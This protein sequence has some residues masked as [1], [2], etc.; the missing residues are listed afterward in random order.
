ML[1]FSLLLRSVWVS[2]VVIGTT[3]VAP[4]TTQAQFSA[5]KRVAVSM[6]PTMVSAKPG[7]SFTL[8]LTATPQSGWY[9]YGL[10]PS[11]DADGIGPQ[12]TEISVGANTLI[13]MNGT[14]KA[15]KPKQKFDKGFQINV[16]YYDSKTTLTIPVRVSATAK[17]G[18][19]TAFALFSY[20]S[21]D[22][23]RCLPPDED[24]LKFTLTI[25][26]AK[27]NAPTPTDTA[28]N[29]Q[30]S[31]QAPSATNSTPSGTPQASAQKVTQ[32]Q[33]QSEIELKR[34]EGV[35]SFLLFAMGAGASAL[36]TPCVFPMIPITVSFF[37]KRSEKV[38]GKALRDSLAYALGIIG[39]FTA[40]GFAL[41]V[42]FGATGISDFAA[43][44]WVNL[45]I[46]GIFIALAMNLFGAFEIPL[47]TEF[48]NRVN[49]KSN[50]GDGL[51][52]VMLMGLTFS[53]TSF[54]CT[55][56]FVGAA[57]VSAAG[58]EW[59]HPI[60]GMLGFSSVFALPFFLLALFPSALQKL[61]KAGGWMNNVKVVMGFLEIAAALK[62]I[63]NSDL[64][65]NWG[66]ISREVFLSVW[67]GCMVLIVLYIV[68]V[69]R[70][71]HDAPIHGIGTPRALLA[72]VFS[73]MVFYLIGGLFGNALGE[74]DA[75]LPPK[76]YRELVQSGTNGG[77]MVRITSGTGTDSKK[78]EWIT[79]YQTAL[80][81]AQR[82]NKAVFIDFTGFTCTNCRWMEA[83]MFPQS[84]VRTLMDKMVKV[85][86]FTDRRTEPYLSNKKFQLEKFGTIELPFY[87]LV[88]PDGT[89]ITT[90][91]F[92]R[93]SKE[94]IE[95]LRKAT[96]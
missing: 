7:E 12:P 93:D 54:T 29:L 2:L 19:Y 24:S 9:F 15:T 67:I 89:V 49:E 63:S 32:S 35:W 28:Q 22:S 10:Q 78:E 46:A 45:I 53:I 17:P 58:G 69:Y 16:S 42:I 64:V 91:A 20:Q 74:L 40:L 11:K 82:T 76:N 39:T 66:W 79:D 65:W 37:A 81:E 94:F 85:Q 72:V 95:F 18:I 77:G 41:A 38:K 55:V 14:V 61:P 26:D 30:A 43:N 5:Q 48:I 44:P 96:L 23:T 34:S 33:S 92:T 73:T 62:F 47:P 70:F 68:G 36:L 83:N 59:F 21:C 84:D 86:L 51:L 88:K 8:T 4:Q 50:S 27:G 60:I 90:K 1:R 52:S 56:P 31:T 25:T 71:L 87:V 3:L 57:L 75:F 6:S 13:T 80:W